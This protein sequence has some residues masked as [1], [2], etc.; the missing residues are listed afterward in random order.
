MV[1][2]RTCTRH[3]H[4]TAG[5]LRITTHLAHA[6]WNPHDHSTLWLVLGNW[7]P[8]AYFQ[9]RKFQTCISN[10]FPTLIVIWLLGYNDKLKLSHWHHVEIHTVILAGIS[11]LNNK[12]LNSVFQQGLGL[13]PRYRQP[14]R[15]FHGLQEQR[16][17]AFF[18]ASHCQILGKYLLGA[19]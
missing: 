14:G 9:L 8:G 10:V 1:G 3:C 18:E 2:G 16:M 19:I 15:F 5:P 13:V 17:R 11:S 4:R 7:C 6:R 12:K